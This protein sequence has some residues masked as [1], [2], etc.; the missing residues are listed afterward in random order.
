MRDSVRA[1]TPTGP[2]CSLSRFL[3]IT[4]PDT[5][6]RQPFGGQDSGEPAHR[7]SAAGSSLFRPA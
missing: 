2:H 6:D 3:A 7:I 1:I 5:A 4:Y